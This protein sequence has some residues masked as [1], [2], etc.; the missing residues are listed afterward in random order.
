MKKIIC[1]IPTLI[2]LF[3]FTSCSCENISYDSNT[4][5][6]SFTVE[7]IN[8]QEQFSESNIFATDNIVTN[9][10]YSFVYSSNLY[11]SVCIDEI[12]DT[13]YFVEDIDF[14]FD[15]RNEILDDYDN[16][17]EELN[18]NGEFETEIYSLD[19]KQI[20][21]VLNENIQMYMVMAQEEIEK[22]SGSEYYQDY[23]QN[24]EYKLSVFTE[25][26]T[27]NISFT[28]LDNCYV[29]I[30]KPSF[31]DIEICDY[32]YDSI[33]GLEDWVSDGS[34]FA[35]YTVDG[36]IYFSANDLLNITKKE[37]CMIIDDPDVLFYEI[38]DNVLTD[39]TFIIEEINLNYYFSYANDEFDEIYILPAYEINYEWTSFLTYED[40]YKEELVFSKEIAFDAITGLQL[41]TPY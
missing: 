11:F 18:L 1:L 38:Y 37:E 41:F 30:S 26:Y 21:S 33:T 3:V 5:A 24:L 4:V 19:Y 16:L 40:G 6:F 2:L 8:F 34:I 35:I 31:E 29:I 12:F 17:L 36:L 9:S 25:M 13:E 28:D 39:D 10:E 23:V 7:K 32:E 27:E 20:Q 22:Y 14:E 15:S